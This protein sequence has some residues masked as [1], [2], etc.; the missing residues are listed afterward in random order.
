MAVMRAWKAGLL[1][2]ALSLAGLA[3]WVATREQP[4]EDIAT[5]PTAS[6]VP[7]APAGGI[8]AFNRLPP[9][10][11]GVPSSRDLPPMAEG[12]ASVVPDPLAALPPLKDPLLAR[13]RIER[14]YVRVAQGMLVEL[15]RAVGPQREGWRYAAIEFAEPLESGATR[16]MALMS[17]SLADLAAGDVVE[18]RFAAKGPQQ[19]LGMRGSFFMGIERDRVTQLLGKS[20]TALAQ[21]FE[22]RMEA[23]W[24]PDP[25]LALARPVP[26]KSLPL[27]RAIRIVH[28]KG[29]R[30][31]ALF[32]DPNCVACIALEQ[33][34]DVT[35]HV[36]MVPLIRPDLAQQARS[37]WCSPDRARAWLDLTLRRQAPTASPACDNP[38]DALVAQQ[39]ELLDLRATPTMVFEDGQ[40]LQG[41]VSLPVLQERL[42]A[43]AAG[44]PVALR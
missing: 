37:V 33:L 40:R 14:V 11:A 29:T 36:F 13:G 28:G 42:A 1:V 43:A 38:V 4:P 18:M 30:Q 10:A 41:S 9:T 25:A 19:V 8:N 39:R 22:R 44:A 21:A 5:G 32:S 7:R 35:L 16:A 15:S 12:A 6:A 23:R 26:W 34:D 27:E 31:I 20:G 24:G 17:G 2:G 3:A